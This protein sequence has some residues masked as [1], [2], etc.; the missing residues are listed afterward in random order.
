MLNPSRDAEPATVTIELFNRSGSPVTGALMRFDRE[1]KRV[2]RSSSRGFP[3]VDLRM[4]PA[5]TLRL[6][7]GTLQ[8]G[9]TAHY[10]VEGVDGPPQL[11]EGRWIEGD[12]AGREFGRGEFRIE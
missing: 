9:E 12:A 2:D 10:E 6:S 3:D 1:L 5:D 8:P 4:S 11:L 7:G